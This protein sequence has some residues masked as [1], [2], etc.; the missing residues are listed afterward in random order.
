MLNPLI[1]RQVL[2]AGQTLTIDFMR[3]LAKEPVNNWDT[4]TPTVGVSLSEPKQLI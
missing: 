4:D 1:M 2:R 3:E